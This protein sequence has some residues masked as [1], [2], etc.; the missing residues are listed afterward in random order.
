MTR[1][2]PQ[3]SRDGNRPSAECESVGKGGNQPG[4]TGP[5]RKSVDV[6][7]DNSEEKTILSLGGESSIGRK[8]VRTLREILRWFPTNRPRPRLSVRSN[9]AMIREGGEQGR[10]ASRVAF[11]RVARARGLS[12]RFSR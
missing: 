7:V 12:W 6:P 10:A 2:E 3:E 11:H 4:K 9:Q 5:E 8:G 1:T